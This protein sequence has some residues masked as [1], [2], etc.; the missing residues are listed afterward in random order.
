MGAMLM[1]VMLDA[2]RYLQG[3]GMMIYKVLNIIYFSLVVFLFINHFVINSSRLSSKINILANQIVVVLI[4]I[5]VLVLQIV[6]FSS[7]SMTVDYLFGILT[8]ISFVGFTAVVVCVESRLDAYKLDREAAGW[9]EE[10]GYPEGYV[11]EYQKNQK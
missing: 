7:Y 11:H 6:S 2:S 4:A 10:K 9:T 8:I 1:L 5:I 3:N